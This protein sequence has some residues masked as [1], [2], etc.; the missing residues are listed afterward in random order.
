MEVS[1]RKGYT[2]A[3][4]A[5]KNMFGKKK[6]SK[7][8][9]YDHENEKPAVRCSICTGEQVAGFKDV[10]TGKFREIMLISRPDELERFK[11]GCGTDTVE[12]FY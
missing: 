10:R 6:A 12:K 9:A 4:R 11:E 8:I 1:S 2:C 7:P 5:V 3:I